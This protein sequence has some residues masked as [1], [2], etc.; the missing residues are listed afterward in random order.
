MEMSDFR[1]GTLFPVQHRS[2]LRVFTI[3]T[4]KI[5]KPFLK[6]DLKCQETAFMEW[7][8]SIL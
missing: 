3:R 7:A 8:G 2:G 1:V 4:C 5:T 6:Q